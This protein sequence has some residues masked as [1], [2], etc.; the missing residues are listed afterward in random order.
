MR[1][2][3]LLIGPAIILAILAAA[4]WYAVLRSPTPFQ[5]SSAPASG[6]AS[7]SETGLAPAPTPL[8]TLEGELITDK[9]NL[10]SITLP[11]GWKVTASE[12]KKG[13]RLSY[14][15]A[16]SPDF[17]VRAD[18]NTDG[19]FVPQYYERGASFGLHAGPGDP[20]EVM[21][22]PGIASRPIII[23][24]IPGSFRA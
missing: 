7:P 20:N 21:S 2:L 24:S 6:T 4:I 19:P 1:R 18:E 5:T 13:V 14:I 23:D 17:S 3:P 22:R 15:S 12:G 9:S 10:Y 11:T 16:Q 8:P